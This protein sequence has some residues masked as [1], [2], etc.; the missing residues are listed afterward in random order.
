MLDDGKR[1]TRE[2][3]GHMAVEFIKLVFVNE[4]VGKRVYIVTL[5]DLKQGLLE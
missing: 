1:G 5:N 3:E 2:R 4:D